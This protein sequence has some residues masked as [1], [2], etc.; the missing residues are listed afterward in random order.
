MKCSPNLRLWLALGRTFHLAGYWVM[1][2]SRGQGDNKC[3]FQISKNAILAILEIPNFQKHNLRNL[4]NFRK[5][6]RPHLISLL[7]GQRPYYCFSLFSRGRWKLHSSCWSEGCRRSPR[8]N[9]WR[10]DRQWDYLRWWLLPKT[11]LSGGR[12]NGWLIKSSAPDVYHREC[13]DS[14]FTT[15]VCADSFFARTSAFDLRNHIEIK[16][17]QSFN[18]MSWNISLSSSPKGLG[19]WPTPEDSWGDKQ[20]PLEGS[21]WVQIVLGPR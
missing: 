10:P 16:C 7:L 17:R 6:T 20:N 11:S 19:S 18:R 3:S 4:G 13:A 15:R 9:L 21:T 8:E 2:G 14:F 5:P 12:V 1:H